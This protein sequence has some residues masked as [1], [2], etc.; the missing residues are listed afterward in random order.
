MTGSLVLNVQGLAKHFGGSVALDGIDVAVARGTLHALLGGNGSGKSTTVKI[1]AGVCA[2]DAGTIAA[3]GHSFDARSFGPK[4]SREAGLRF[5]HQELALFESISIAENLALSWGF[6]RTGLHGIAWRTLSRRV[7]DLLEQY[8][9]SARPSTPVG[10]LRPATKTMVAVAR[11]MA[12]APETDSILV[13][14]EPTASFSERDASALLESVSRRVAAGQSVILISHR[15]RE[16]TAVADEVTVLRD[17]RVAGTLTRAS[18]DERSIVRLMAGETVGE[19]RDIANDRTPIGA[20]RLTIAGLVAG[21]LSGMDLDVR[22]GE[23][24]GVTGLPGSGRSTLLR[25]V[26]GDIARTAGTIEIDGRTIDC[27]SPSSAMR[28]GIAYVPEDRGGEA[29][30]A[31]LDL[32]DNMSAAVLDRYWRRGWM[33]RKAERADTAKLERDYHIK[34]SSPRAAFSSLSG[35]NQQ[36]AVL[37]RWL[38]RRPT[39]LLLDEPTQGV[40]VVARA[41]IYRLV[42]HAAADGC[43]VVVASSDFDE[44]VTLTDRVV[45]LRAG[46]VA[47]TVAGAQLTESH[48]A[49]LVH[50]GAPVTTQ[51]EMS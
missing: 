17:G 19:L 28:N 32:T 44:L 24:I 31:A 47:C 23:I 50:A 18:T 38:R 43:A 48:L 35:G 33:R 20:R 3:G 2:A 15:L 45:I 21:P 12:D 16:V 6:P 29:A 25:S 34:A 40:D 22:A 13:L 36:K 51:G 1:L 7:S 49:E 37:A 30:F 14:D 26:F 5:V 46:E 9:I 42:R 4:M 10:E 8:E 11:A 41:E 27:A 39:V